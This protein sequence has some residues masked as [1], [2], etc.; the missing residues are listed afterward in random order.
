MFCF[1]LFKQKKQNKITSIGFYVVSTRIYTPEEP[2][3]IIWTKLS[4]CHQS[5]P[6]FPSII[7]LM[8]IYSAIRQS[9]IPQFTQTCLLNSLPLLFL[10]TF[11]SGSVRTECFSTNSGFRVKFSAHAL[12][13]DS[14]FHVLL[15]ETDT[16]YL[17]YLPTVCFFTEL[18][19]WK[20][21]LS[22]PMC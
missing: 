18:T 10:F 16:S 5:L 6:W 17:H 13:A 11:S 9:G 2:N 20:L 21:C 14:A 3:E 15:S 22:R 1:L 4:W 7:R 12:I 8:I 19:C